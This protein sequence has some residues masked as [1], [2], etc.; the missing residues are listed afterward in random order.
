MARGRFYVDTSA[1]L[2]LLLG[3]PG[4]QR[5]ESELRDGDLVSSVLL[6][7]EADRGL[8]HLSRTGRLAAADAQRAFERL[9][10]ELEDF[11]LR[12]VTS[13]LCVSRVMPLISTPRSLDLVHLRTALWFH[14][15]RPLTRFVSLDGAQNQ[16]ARE[17]G[18]PVDVG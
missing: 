1:Y 7:L 2:C 9:L 11:T 4:A 18:L 14:R 15:E 13:D 6:L 12:D 17:L 10:H 5:L 8:V 16:A 3:E